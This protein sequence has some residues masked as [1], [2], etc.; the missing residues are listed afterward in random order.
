MI[1]FNLRTV[2]NKIAEIYT[3][4]TQKTDRIVIA[5][6]RLLYVY[7]IIGVDIERKPHARLPVSGLISRC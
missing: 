6:D 1:L 5:G 3:N 2:F 4:C 7:F